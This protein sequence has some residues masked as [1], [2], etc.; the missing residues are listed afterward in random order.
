MTVF[1]L[2]NI[3]GASE[4]SFYHHAAINPWLMG[5]IFVAAIAMVFWLY[6]AQQRIASR[7]LVAALTALRVLLLLALLVL[8]L[9]PAVRWTHR[10][11]SAGTLWLLLDGTGSMATTDPQST[12]VERLRWAE[13]LEYLPADARPVKLDQT[14]ADLVCLRDDLSRFR[15]AASYPHGEASIEEF[16]KSL[17]TWQK[18]LDDAAAQL[19]KDGKSQPAANLFSSN[20]GQT[21]KLA[22]DGISAA[23]TKKNIAEAIGAIPWPRV[24]ADLDLAVKILTPIAERA[25]TEFVQAHGGDAGVKDAIAKVSKLSRAQLAELALT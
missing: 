6:R 18:R 17:K 23:E 24:E 1:E 15:S 25:D 4:R 12:A 19:A 7:R 13:A 3:L 2:F 5:L 9:Q 22:S 14:L 8:L 21:S 10:Q 16:A 11:S 20:L